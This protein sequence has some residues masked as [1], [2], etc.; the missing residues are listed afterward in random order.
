MA[1]QLP[2]AFKEIIESEKNEIVL[3][4]GRLGGKSN[5]TAKVAILTMLANPYYDVIVARVSYGSMADSSYSELRNAI[6]EMGDD[7]IDEFELKKSPLRIARK[8]NAGD[9]YFI[10]YGGSNTSRTKSIRTK[11][12]IKVVILEETQELKSRR[13]LDEALASFRRHF[14]DRV[15]VFILGNPPPQEAHWFN[16]YIAEKQFDFDTLVKR[17]TYLDILPFINDYDLR[18]IVKLKYTD[19]DYYKWFYL[20]ETTGGFGSVYPMFRKE[21]HVISMQQWERIRE[22]GKIRVV[23]L[24]IGGDGAVNR[25]STAFVPILL[26]S[27]GQSAVA[28]IFYHNPQDDGVIGYHQLVQ[29]HLTRWLDEICQRF[30]LGTAQELRM[31]PYMKQVPIWMRIDSASPDLIQECRFFLGDRCSIAPIKKK[32]VFEMV[33]VCQSTIA[34]NNMVI[35]DYGGYYSYVKNRFIKKNV[36]LLEEQLSMLIWNERQDNYD[37]VVPNDVCDAWTYGNFFWYSNQENI[38]YFNI[39]KMNNGKN[40]LISDILKNKE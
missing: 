37:P 29:D 26:L 17:V 39:V 3:Y 7:I 8:G 27:N 10:G 11:H 33:G 22:S 40:I 12:K 30:R 2:L 19:P 16:R 20:G 18:E 31:H 25:D 38:Q 13:N 14:G 5:G 34:N 1:I 21:K 24:V 36:N 35:I 15:K 28:P 32:H 23:G 9:I 4:G 6:E